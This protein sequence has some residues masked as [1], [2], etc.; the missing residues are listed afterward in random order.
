MPGTIYQE[1]D[2][3]VTLTITL[4][5]LVNAATQASTVVSSVATSTKFLDAL[6]TASNYIATAPTSDQAIYYYAYGST[7]GGTTYTDNASGTDARLTTGRRNAQPLGTVI[8]TSPS[9]VCRGG[10][11]S[12]A[13]CFGGV[14]PARW[15]VIAVNSTG[16]YLDNSTATANELKFQ[17]VWEQYT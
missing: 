14:L 9:T 13:R 2:N 1:F 3:T 12:V 10:P 17:H 16:T 8:I 7:D 5:G 4:N 6:I 11:W 15:G